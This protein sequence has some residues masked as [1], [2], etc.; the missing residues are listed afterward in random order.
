MESEGAVVTREVVVLL[1]AREERKAEQIERGL[2]G[3]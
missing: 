3:A 2:H 1:G